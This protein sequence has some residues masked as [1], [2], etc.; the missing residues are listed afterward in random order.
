MNRTVS[1][2]PAALLLGS[3]L[4]AMPAAAEHRE[5]GAHEHGIGKLNVVLEEHDLH[6]E[7]DSPAANLVGFEH[8]PH[9]AE[10]EKVLNQAVSRL[11]HGADLFALPRAAACRLESAALESP[12]FEGETA[13]HHETPPHHEEHEGAHPHGEGHAQHDGGEE[14]GH[15]H[16]DIRAHYR[17]HCDNPSQLDGMTVRLFELFPGT[18][19]L[20]VQLLTPG[21][22]GAAELTAGNPRLHF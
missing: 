19:E 21:K 14:A 5:H 3:A 16:A 2:L 18:G 17:F 10:Q 1:T 15:G 13:E 22:Q 4:A 20:E 11:K 8:A 7:L 12:L 6:I 9:T